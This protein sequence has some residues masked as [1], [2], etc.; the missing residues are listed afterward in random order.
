V[1]YASAKKPRLT[2]ECAEELRNAIE[3]LAA[4]TAAECV[5]RGFCRG[6]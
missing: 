2:M 6:A 4:E 1:R 5:T 3:A